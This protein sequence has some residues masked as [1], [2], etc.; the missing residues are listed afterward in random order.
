VQAQKSYRPGLRIADRIQEQARANINSLPQ[1]TPCHAGLDPAA[2]NVGGQ[3]MQ[4]RPDVSSKQSSTGAMVP[5]Q[6]YWIISGIS[7]QDN[8][9]FVEGILNED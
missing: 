4:L 9:I 8:R 7:R 5:D 1:P 2:K 6:T 3:F